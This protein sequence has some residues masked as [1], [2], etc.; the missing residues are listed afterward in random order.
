[1]K[2]KRIAIFLICLL[3]ILLIVLFCYQWRNLDQNIS[4]I[5]Q[6]VANNQK[7]FLEQKITGP[8]MLELKAHGSKTVII[9]SKEVQRINSHIDALT[10][11]IR[12]ESHRAESIIDKDLDRLNLLITVGIGFM[13]MLGVFVPFI[14]NLISVQD[15][16]EQQESIVE[17]MGDTKRHLDL[18]HLK[19]CN[20]TLQHAVAR[21]YNVAPIIM[22]HTAEDGGSYITEL[23]ENLKI[24]L[25]GCR[26]DREHKIFGNKPFLQ[27]I[28]DLQRLFSGRIIVH[29]VFETRAQTNEV[30][31]MNIAFRNLK[32]SEQDREKENYT[33]LF[34]KIDAVTETWRK[35]SKK[36]DESKAA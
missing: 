23:F 33:T 30:T 5:K 14:V 3:L 16:R 29:S 19:V 17:R 20:L 31:E 35:V 18:A 22:A 21:F 24:A 11:E 8:L 15:L 32:A 4:S 26:D 10:S 34:E 27:S 6:D 1:M 2:F 13:A 25:E 9:D 28:D 12:N 36:N 7:K